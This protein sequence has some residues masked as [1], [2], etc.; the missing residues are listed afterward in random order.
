MDRDVSGAT[1]VVG[2]AGGRENNKSTC[3]Y[4][5]AP[6]VQYER[7]GHAE[8]VQVRAMH[9]CVQLGWG[10]AVS[11]HVQLRKPACL[12]YHETR[13]LRNAVALT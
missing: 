2:Y 13:G 1:A 12:L 6:D 3:Y 11:A 8:V 9:T 7:Q 5:N 4:Y 10:W